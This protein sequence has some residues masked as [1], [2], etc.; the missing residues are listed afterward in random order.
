[1]KSFQRFLMALVLLVGCLPMGSAARA[2]EP[3]KPSENWLLDASDDMERF[4]R[5]QQ[6][7]GGFSGAML[8][9]AERYDRAYDA[10][11]DKNYELAGYH[12]RKIKE[13]IELGY[14]R[15]PARQAHSDALFLKGPWVSTNDAL[16]SKDE[17]KIREAFLAARSACMACHAAEQASFINEQP[18]FRRTAR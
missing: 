7:F 11:A 12:W 15:R 17:P 5:I 18:L 1:M 9:V 2:D 6:M 10:I 14:L 3:P 13:S 16:A 8:V 4:K